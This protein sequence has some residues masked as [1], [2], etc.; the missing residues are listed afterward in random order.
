MPRKAEQK[1]RGNV[2][3]SNAKKEIRII[4]KNVHKKGMQILHTF[5][6]KKRRSQSEAR[7][8]ARKCQQKNEPRANS[9]KS[10]IFLYNLN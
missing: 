1:K 7:E 4:R 3:K 2:T 10:P 9:E 5:A 8:N 6:H